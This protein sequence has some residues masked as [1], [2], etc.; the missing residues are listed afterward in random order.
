MDSESDSDRA[1]ANPIAFVKIIKMCPSLSKNFKYVM[2]DLNNPMFRPEES[3][4]VDGFGDSGLHPPV[5]KGGR[6]HGDEKIVLGSNGS[7][8]SSI[9]ISVHLDSRSVKQTDF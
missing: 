6:G 2:H 5:R 7:G 8:I 9:P 1:D 4:N 3:G